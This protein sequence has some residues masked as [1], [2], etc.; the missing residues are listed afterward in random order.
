MSER[1]V[2][3]FRSSIGSKCS[4]TIAKPTSI[5]S[6]ILPLITY[7]ACSNSSI[8]SGY[9]TLPLKVSHSKINF[10]NSKITSTIIPFNKDGI[11]AL[12]SNNKVP[13]DRGEGTLIGSCRTRS[14]LISTKVYSFTIFICRVGGRSL[15][16][17]V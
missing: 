17:E 9:A 5:V 14:N 15:V 6:V 13:L 3:S 4:T 10:S 1:R 8:K 16:K 12:R 2:L 11:D 7:R